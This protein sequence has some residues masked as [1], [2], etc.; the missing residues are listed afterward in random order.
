MSDDS[1]GLTARGLQHTGEVFIQDGL[2]ILVRGARQERQGMR[3]ELRSTPYYLS[4]LPF[5]LL[6]KNKHG[7]THT[8]EKKTQQFHSL[9][10]KYKTKSITNLLDLLEPL[11]RGAEGVLL[12]LQALQA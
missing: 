10:V 3:G 11:L 4:V 12:S 6:A 9:M 2:G 5:F 7:I 1:R 8:L